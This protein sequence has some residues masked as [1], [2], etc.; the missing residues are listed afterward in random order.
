[1]NMPAHCQGWRP[2]AQAIA[3]EPI[4]RLVVM[5]TWRPLVQNEYIRAR[6][7]RD[8][9]PGQLALLATATEPLW[10]A[11]DAS[12]AGDT[13][14]TGVNPVPIQQRRSWAEL[15]QLLTSNDVVVTGHPDD[16]PTTDRNQRP[17]HIG[18]FARG[19]PLGGVGSRVQITGEDHSQALWR[20]DE[21]LFSPDQQVVGQRD[22]QQNGRTAPRG[23]C[24]AL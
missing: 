10:I 7:K 14:P 23:W 21:P 6:S 9:N 24:H 3:D 16:Q 11:D 5:L 13:R 8:A 15:Y 20:R 19:A 4:A 2:T 12:D 22:T 18:D 17:P 1:M